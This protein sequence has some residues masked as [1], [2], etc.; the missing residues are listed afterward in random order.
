MSYYGCNTKCFKGEFIKAGR[1]PYPTSIQYAQN[2][3]NKVG[4]HREDDSTR[5]DFSEFRDAI[6]GVQVLPAD[7]FS[8]IETQYHS[9]SNS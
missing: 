3:K 6:N 5:Y 7:P 9:N 4:T 1:S 8:S 2:I